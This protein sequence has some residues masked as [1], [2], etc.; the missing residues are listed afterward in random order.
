[1]VGENFGKLIIQNPEETEIDLK[2]GDNP[3][4]VLKIL[5]NASFNFQDLQLERKVE[6][7]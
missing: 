7:S 3:V 5:K 6:K 4:K 1:M 2:I